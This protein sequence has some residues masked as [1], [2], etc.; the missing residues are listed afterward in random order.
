MF[1]RAR[2]GATNGSSQ[3]FNFN[4]DQPLYVNEKLGRVA[5]INMNAQGSD[6]T[7]VRQP[8]AYQTYTLAGNESSESFFV[9][10]RDNA[11]RDRVGILIEQVDEDYLERHGLDPNGALYKFVQRANLNPVFSVP[12]C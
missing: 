1:A 5:E 6:S 12:A 3:K 8:M 10:M 11:T 7:F 4:D 9:L 2:G